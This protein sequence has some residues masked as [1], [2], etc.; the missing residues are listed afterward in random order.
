[1]LVIVQIKP[2]TS[3]SGPARPFTL[4][5]KIET[6]LFGERSQEGRNGRFENLADNLAESMR[7]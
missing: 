5:V 7:W 1:M 4:V 3:F 6:V 2:S